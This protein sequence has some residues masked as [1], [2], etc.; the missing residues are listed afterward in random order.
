V[1]VKATG[2]LLRPATEA[3]VAALEQ[4]HRG[5]AEFELPGRSFN[6]AEPLREPGPGEIYVVAQPFIEFEGE[7]EHERW[8]GAEYHGRFVSTEHD[9]TLDLLELVEDAK[10]NL[11]D[12]FADMRIAGFDVSRWDVRA[13]PSA[14]VL[15]P[16]LD[17]RLAPRRR[18]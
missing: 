3:E 6:Y 17:A 18:G 1:H 15:D 8:D 10:E 12:L 2:V 7:G 14:I 9:A 5:G 4:A 13:A 11:V 16:A